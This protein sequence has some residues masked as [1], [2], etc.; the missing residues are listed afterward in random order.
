MGRYEKPTKK[1]SC[2]MQKAWG[3]NFLDGQAE[4]LISCGCNGIFR[5]KAL[6]ASVNTVFHNTRYLLMKLQAFPKFICSCSFL[7][8]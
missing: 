1:F 3:H 4:W 8:F 6:T 2:T 7:N 5:R